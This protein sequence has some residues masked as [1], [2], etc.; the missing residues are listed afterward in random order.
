MQDERDT[1]DGLEDHLS[2]RVVIAIDGLSS[3][4]KTTLAKDLARHLQWLHIDSGAMYR[5]LTWLMIQKGWTIEELLQH[6]EDVELELTRENGEA[7][8]RINGQVVRDE[9][10]D[11]RVT[12]HVS[13][14]SMIP[15][16]RRFLVEKQRAAARNAS[17]IM[18]GRDIGTVVFPHADIKFYLTADED[19][20]VQRRHRE[21]LEKGYDI[22]EEEVRRQIRQRDHLDTTRAHSPLR[23]AEDAI[24]LDTSHLSRSEQLEEALKII[25]RRLEKI[26]S[27]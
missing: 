17:V 13:A 18:D 2:R 9:L 23:K 6:L 14:V 19:V 12:E 26:T 8:I 11:P 20:R 4:G 7:L 3:C 25:R 15:E 16:V 21:L 5:A 10:R 27:P 24:V 22:D 1:Q